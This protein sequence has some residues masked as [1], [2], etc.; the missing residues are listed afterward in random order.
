[1]CFKQ[2][3]AAHKAGDLGKAEELYRQLVKAQPK[4]AEGL[5]NLGALLVE[6]HGMAK[7]FGRV[8]H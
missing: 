3:C 7:V 6:A 1:M 2:A 8:W 4:H 5:H